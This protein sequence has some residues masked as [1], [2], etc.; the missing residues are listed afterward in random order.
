[1][2]YS[3]SSEEIVLSC[4]HF[5]SLTPYVDSLTLLFSMGRGREPEA[6]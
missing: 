6:L 3:L 1:M 4:D 2:L 5:Q